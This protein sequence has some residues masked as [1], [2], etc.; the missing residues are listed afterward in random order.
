[1]LLAIRLFG[2]G[3]KWEAAVLTE[4][5]KIDGGNDWSYTLDEGDRVLICVDPKM[6]VRMKPVDVEVG[7][8][9]GFWRS[10]NRLTL[11]DRKGK[12]QRLEI[13]QEALK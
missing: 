2:A 1:L 9:V 13:Q 3:Q 12:E 6:R 11:I 7:R 5:H 4:M 10:K 8:P